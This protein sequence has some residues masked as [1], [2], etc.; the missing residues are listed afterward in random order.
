[1]L[2]NGLPGSGKTTIGA[3]LAEVLDCPFLSKDAVKEP[4]ADIVGPMIP[5]RQLG[6]IAMDT[7]WAMAGAVEA[8]V[9][10]DSV[11]LEGR[12]R[13]FL[14][15]GLVAAGS[16]RV[17]EVW[18]DASRESIVARLDARYAASPARHVVHGTRDEVLAA[19]DEHADA[20]PLG[21]AGGWPVVRVDTAAGFDVAELMREIAGHFGA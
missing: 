6:G 7:V 18:C 15:A 21:I 12:D 2:V 1:M 19:W 14:E 9:V 20:E 16:P 13:S 11:W 4:L 17:V 3:S 8:G 5:S 10:I